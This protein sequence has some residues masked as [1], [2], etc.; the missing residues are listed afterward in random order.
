[1]GI[2]EDQA[3]TCTKEQLLMGVQCALDETDTAEM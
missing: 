1:M 2:K 3:G